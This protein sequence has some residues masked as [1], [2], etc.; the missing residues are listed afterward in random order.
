MRGTPA[1][2][3]PMALE[4]LGRPLLTDDL[5]YNLDVGIVASSNHVLALVFVEPPGI[6][7]S[8]ALAVDGPQ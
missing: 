7:A 1:S 3:S 2:V 8:G 6:W 4:D 5:A